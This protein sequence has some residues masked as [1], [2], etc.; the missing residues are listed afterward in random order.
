MCKPDSDG[1]TAFGITQTAVHSPRGAAYP[2]LF[3]RLPSI[4]FRPTLVPVSLEPKEISRRFLFLQKKAKSGQ[5]SACVLRELS[6]R[7]WRPSRGRGLAPSWEPHSASQHQARVQPGLRA[8]V[9]HLISLRVSLLLLQVNVALGVTHYVAIW[10]LIFEVW[11]HSNHFPCELMVTASMLRPFLLRKL[12]GK[13]YFQMG[14][15][16][17][18][19]HAHTMGVLFLNAPNS[20]N[21]DVYQQRVHKSCT[22]QSTNVAIRTNGLTKCNKDVYGSHNAEPKKTR[23][24]NKGQAQCHSK[25]VLSKQVTLYCRN[26][27]RW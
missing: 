10:Q 24:N 14:G 8:F 17:E 16:T 22:I 5:C 9:L 18:H 3:K 20:N 2:P 4:T 25:Q 26:V 27:Y 15:L 13:L 19:Q 23:K 21:P 6:Q 1:G 11:E 7:W 12:T